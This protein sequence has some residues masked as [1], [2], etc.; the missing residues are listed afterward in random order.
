[1]T[2]RQ[3]PRFH[4]YFRYLEGR[5]V[6]L[7]S[8]RDWVHLSR[9][10]Q[11]EIIEIG[12]STTPIAGVTRNSLIEAIVAVR[13][14]ASEVLVEVYRYD[15]KDAPTPIN[16]DRYRIWERLPTHTDYMFIVNSA[17]TEDNP[18]MRGFLEDHVFLVKDVLTSG[19]W[20]REIPP[21]VKAVLKDR[22]GGAT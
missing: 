12:L 9:M 19:H 7:M 13:Q 3:A 17:S 15:P 2:L 10:E 14:S 4:A 21:Q 16:V 6:M 18:N 8:R 22:R 20:L 5:Q 11:G 1:M